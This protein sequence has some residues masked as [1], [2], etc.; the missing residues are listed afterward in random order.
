MLENLPI[1][2]VCGWSGSGKTTLLEKLIPV[3]RRKGLDVAVVKHDAHGVDVDRPGKDSDRL[4][5]AGADV[6]LRGPDQS[7]ARTHPHRR[8]ALPEVLRDLTTRYDLVLIEGH[9]D[10]PLPKIWLRSD[11][12]DG[13]PASVV[14]V[15]ASL[16]WDGDRVGTAE[17]IV[18]KLIRSRLADTPVLGCVLIGGKSL[19]MGCPKHL[20]RTDGTTWIERTVAVLEE[21]VSGVVIVGSG[22]L[23]AS[24]SRCLRLPDAPDIAGPMAGVLTAM[25]W[26]PY[27]S[28][29][30]SACDLPD[31]QSSALTWLLSA[32]RPGAWAVLPKRD[33]GLHVEPLLAWYDFRAHL[34][35]EAIVA[36]GSSRIA[37]IT[38]NP[39]CLTPLIPRRLRGAWR[40][41]NNP[42]AL[43]TLSG[44]S[45]S[46]VAG[47][48]GISG[49]R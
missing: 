19:R 16:A 48:S 28:W 26:S 30:V 42:E 38:V 20:L 1:L 8:A 6:V 29:I 14:G 15:M 44:G 24:L 12:E 33:P 43:R 32:R 47:I 23:P 34:P 41:C 3:L 37:D 9:K 49:N 45:K 13:P 27:C 4:Y 36:A 40:N 17:S 10:T 22:E 21:V 31:L 18:D 7:F 11:G 39:K 2:G 25:R 5:R 35:M 46:S